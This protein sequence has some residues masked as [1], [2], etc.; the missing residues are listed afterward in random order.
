MQRDGAY[1][2][3]TGARRWGVEVARRPKALAARLLRS[4]RC[5][6]LTSGTFPFPVPEQGCPQR[7]S[8]ACF[9]DALHG[10]LAFTRAPLCPPAM[11]ILL[12]QVV[13]PVVA[14]PDS[15]LAHERLISLM[16]DDTASNMVRR[17]GAPQAWGC[18]AAATSK[19]RHGVRGQARIRVLEEWAFNG[20]LW[21]RA[22]H[23][24]GGQGQGNQL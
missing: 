22:T 10:F 18:R 19:C 13:R 7:P 23:D 20:V 15:D 17:G 21:M 16:R 5:I 4:V 24:T 3:R 2:Q 6:Q 9:P 12:D 11:D 8:L 1:N 14:Q